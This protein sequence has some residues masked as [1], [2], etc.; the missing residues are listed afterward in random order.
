MK[1]HILFIVAIL[2][3]LTGFAQGGYDPENPG[4]PDPYRRLSVTASPKA[5]GRVGTNNNSQQ[6]KVG[7]TVSCYAD[8]NQY[9][10]FV[11]WLMNG[12]IVSTETRY[13]FDM[14][15]EN[16][17]MT[18]VFELNYN[19]Q[20]PGDPQ[21]PIPSHR[22]TLTASPGKGG[23]FNNSVFRLCE[24]DSVNVYAYPNS[25]YRF[26]EWLLNGV[27]LS[28]KNP[29]KV[30]MTDKDLHFTA[31]FSY[32]PTNP[33]DPGANLFNEATGEMVVD[34][35]E[36]GELSSAIYALID[37][38]SYSDILSLL[39][40][41]MMSECDFGV[42]YY[43]S[44]CSVIDLSRT[45]GYTE[46]PSYSFESLTSLTELSLPSCVNSIGSYA[47]MGCEN[48]SVIN[49][50]AVIP[51]SLD[52]DV[53]DGVDSV[54]VIKVPAQ[55]IELYKSAE[56][57]KDYTILPA[58]ENV[59]SISVAL[60]SD[61]GDGRYKNMN[62]ELFNTS[63]GQRYK[64][65][66]TDRK[67][68]VFGNLLSSTKYS[69][70][71]KNS[72]GEILGEITDLE[73]VDKD[74]SVS[75]ES[76]LQP[77]NLSLQ[78]VTPD[79]ED[80]TG[81]VTIKWFNESHELLQQGSALKGVLPNTVISY[82][83]ILP[84]QLQSI[85]SQPSPTTLTVTDSNPLTC[86]L[87]AIGK[88]SL[89]GKITD[90]EG[91]PVSSATVTVSQN[92]NGSYVKSEN[93]FCDKDG[94][95]S[96]EV[97][98]VPV[99]ITVSADEYITQIKEMQTVPD[100]LG[101][102]IL[103][104]ALGITIFPS[105]T[106]IESVP[107]GETASETDRYYNEANI[108][109]RV[110]DADGNEIADC[111]YQSGSIILPMTVVVGDN[112]TVTAY[113][114]DNKFNDVSM[115]LALTSKR[116]HVKLA[117]VEHGGINVNV[118]DT[119]DATNECLLYG[120]DD[121]QISKSTLGKNGVSFTNLPDGKYSLVTM[122]K[123][124]LIGSVQNL[125]TIRQTALKEGK[126]YIVS[127]IDVASGHIS[128]VT[129][130]GVPV[131]DESKLYY[132]ESK[133][134]YFMPY[135]SQLTIGN[136]MTLKAKLTIKDEYADEIDAAT[137]VVDIPS[138]CEF[139]ENSVISGSGYLGYEYGRNRLSVPMQNLSETVR[140]CI[141][142]L[143]GGDCKPSA[144]I[145]LI[146]GNEE[147]LQPIGTAYFEAKNFSLAAPQKTC[148]TNIP[149]R[150]T[151]TSD[152]E[153]KIYDNGKLAGTTY[154]KPNGEWSI[155]LSL[156]NSYLKSTHTLYGEVIT[157]EGKRLL[158]QSRI[159]EYDQSY[160]D[161]SKVTMVYD[162]HDVKGNIIFDYL[163]G[164]SSA[165]SYAYNPDYSDFSFIADFTNNDP[166]IISNV[167]FVVKMLNGMIRYIPADYS[168]VTGNWVARSH[169]SSETLPTNVTADYY[170]QSDVSALYSEERYLSLNETTENICDSFE[171]QL[172]ISELNILDESN[173]HIEGSLNLENG[174]IGNMTVKELS[175]DDNKL[176]S[177]DA[178]EYTDDNETYH[179]IF[180]AEENSMTLIFWSDQKAFEI[181]LSDS[182]TDKVISRASTDYNPIQRTIIFI[183]RLLGNGDIV[184]L[185][186]DLNE[187]NRRYGLTLSNHYKLDLLI[188]QLLAAKCSDKKSRLTDADYQ[189]YE[190]CRRLYRSDAK[191]F[192]ESLKYEI[193]S[194]KNDIESLVGLR[195]L[196]KTASALTAIA[197]SGSSI[198]MSLKNIL[199]RA[200][201]IEWGRSFL[202]NQFE[203]FAGHLVE[204]LFDA[205]NR[206]EYLSKWYWEQENNLRE[207]YVSL[208]RDIRGSYRQ[209][210]KEEEDDDTEDPGEVFPVPPVTPKIDPSGYVYEAVPS[211]RISGVTATA[212]YKQQTE[213]MYGEITETT[214]V[215]DAAP[216]GQ[217]NPLITDENGK[218][219]WDVPAGMWQV[220]FEKEGYEP[221]RSAWLPVPP[222]QLDVNIA[223]T[224]AKQPEV[225]SVHT[226]SD[227][228][229]I[230][231]DKFML[232]SSLD[233]GNIAITQ[234]GTIVNGT[235]QTLDLQLD[236]D[237]NAFC[238]KVEYKPKTLLM[239]LCSSARMSRAMQTST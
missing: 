209:C 85:Y 157:N 220:R 12:E 100:D 207:N 65:L 80:I 108:A 114:K 116:E 191:Y 90:Q 166:N 98:D 149:V 197:T 231:F 35:F 122:N 120:S 208:S 205:K 132:T 45:N 142:P 61:A 173:N 135:K 193:S 164:K 94:N 53:F 167:V 175:L 46:I 140:F 199:S 89:I 111:I 97:P 15:D 51:P 203:N 201:C 168:A 91:Q 86:K 213:D 44:N 105:Y 134:T 232:P 234:N 50:Y 136:Y 235:V 68:Y 198:V 84:Q 14:P 226:Y 185:Y 87:R 99:K 127:T 107:D 131:L 161:L 40:N 195:T 52:S 227:G 76:L 19:P 155:M 22:V 64:Y 188:S 124:T 186:D 62:I 39:V 210:P 30:K 63:N 109:Y 223:M 33:T 24:G 138:N 47:F 36:N 16:V 58:D 8:E 7:Q 21:E 1:H 225:K 71:V 56:G 176:N 106:F 66:I 27:L 228:V 144:F 212:Y 214:V 93:A 10:E 129:I 79:D 67:M 222:P 55:S 230:E 28:T 137:L 25:G 18:A 96:I 174:F 146:I 88:T 159:V 74:L 133:E 187:W 26:E 172:N 101:E 153:V 184:D 34:R 154:S 60:P 2:S 190:T 43:M 117:I 82:A 81:D 20:N 121:I 69:V 147:I 233:L 73:V 145:K 217:E 236:P 49:C 181:V 150:G 151:A 123:S 115:P 219:A 180:S 211:N 75:F 215:W 204:N 102:I 4:D 216:Y 239:P 158:T 130:A 224:Q 139:V 196:L 17:A 143:E 113:S 29:L 57:W 182:E 95:F 206:S 5:G 9:Y 54:L 148:K 83:V 31:R 202:Q 59:F 6:I 221:A 13:S 118:S 229:T 110:E 194:Y 160:I 237:G 170:L 70:F 92:I 42:M 218:Y 23:R 163:N 103:E 165:N 192:E 128:E 112:V 200:F 126:D 183:N 189:F 32:N 171:D 48:L 178:Y 78:V 119:E 72:K 162:N 3:Y 125:S 141:I 169:F 11:H 38:Y 152:S 177:D 37:N 77:Q 179:Y 41:G 238:T 104:K 156:Q